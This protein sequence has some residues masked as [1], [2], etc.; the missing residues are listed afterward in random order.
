MIEFIMF[1]GIS[2]YVVVLCSGISL[3]RKDIEGLKD[4]L[5]ELKEK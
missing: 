4:L 1:V 2:L 3:I 5:N